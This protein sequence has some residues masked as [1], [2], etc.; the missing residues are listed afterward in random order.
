MTITIIDREA[1]EGA[2]HA[3]LSF[4]Y[5]NATKTWKG[6][7][8]EGGRPFETK[9]WMRTQKSDESSKGYT[10]ISITPGT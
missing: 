3:R 2:A 9:A 5:G 1:Q 4:N 8:G 6:E 7:K 10:V